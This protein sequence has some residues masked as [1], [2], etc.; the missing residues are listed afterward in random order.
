MPEFPPLLLPLL[1]SVASALAA[2]AL[3]SAAAEDAAHRRIGNS[4]CATV[5]AS[6]LALLAQLPPAAIL[7]H[8]AIALGFLLAGTFAFARGLVGGGDV[9]LF[10]ASLLWAGPDLLR[11]HLAGTALV[12]VAMGVVMLGRAAV[13][14]RGREGLEAPG[15]EATMPFGVA[16][17]AGGLLV[18]LERAGLL[19]GGM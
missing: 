18:L 2:A 17:A 6:S 4:L 9:K 15:T 1:V 8:L 3:L 10:A 5:A 7:L 13:A 11:L 14:G 12:A 16:I 19:G